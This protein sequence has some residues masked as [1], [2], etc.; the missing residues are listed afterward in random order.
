MTLKE[1]LMVKSYLFDRA[2]KIAAKIISIILHPLLMPTF[3]LFLFFQSPSYLAYIQSDIQQMFYL[4]YVLATFLIP[5]TAIPLLVSLGFISSL[6]MP[7]HKERRIPLIFTAFAYTITHFLLY[8]LPF[9]VP[10]IIRFLPL[11]GAIALVIAAVISNYWKISLHMIGIGGALGALIALNYLYMSNVMPYMLLILGLAGLLGTMRLMTN[12][13]TPPQ[14]Y[15]GFF[16]G[17]ATVF[18]VLYFFT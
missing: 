10:A 1:Q 18:S 8:R 15:T 9:A 11:A 2:L 13:H 14:I 5:L 6:E 4:F 3:V 16:L 17:I 12:A 7:N